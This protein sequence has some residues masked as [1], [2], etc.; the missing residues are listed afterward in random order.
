MDESMMKIKVFKA[1]MK[2]NVA[3]VILLPAVI[4][5]P[6]SLHS[7]MYKILMWVVIFFEYE[8]NCEGSYLPA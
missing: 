7:L 2:A 1:Q 3:T 6:I 4:F 8:A 5:E